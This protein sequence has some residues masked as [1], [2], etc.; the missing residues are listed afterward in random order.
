MDNIISTTERDPE[1]IISNYNKIHEIIRN[2]GKSISRNVKLKLHMIT[3]RPLLMFSSETWT[4]GNKDDVSL[5]AQHT[6]FL[7]KDQMP[8]EIIREEL[9]VID[10]VTDV[11]YRLNWRT[12]GENGKARVP[13]KAYYYIPRGR[14]EVDR[15]I[16]NGLS[17]VSLRTGPGGLIHC[18][19]KGLLV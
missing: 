19:R 16:K 4:L 6:R 18:F 17:I 5:Q 3:A 9:Q 12:S 10:V 1:N 11:K 7:K 8:N 13:K 14:R 2:S 15:P